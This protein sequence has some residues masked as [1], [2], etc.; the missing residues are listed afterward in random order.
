MYEDRM[1]MQ[2]LNTVYSVREETQMHQKQ[3]AES[4]V[5]FHSVVSSKQEVKK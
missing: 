3:T 1:C 2:F 5:D 4:L